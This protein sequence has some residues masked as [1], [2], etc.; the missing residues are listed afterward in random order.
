MMAVTSVTKDTAK[1]YTDCGRRPVG[2]GSARFATT[3]MT[4]NPTIAI[5]AS[6]AATSTITPATAPKPTDD[7]KDDVGEEKTVLAPEL[8]LA[9]TVPVFVVI[10]VPEQVTVSST[11][12]MIMVSPSVR[13]GREWPQR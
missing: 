13:A 7:V 1:K 10:P 8:V 9:H 4:K 5:R 11:A 2:S 12:A 6:R 3:M